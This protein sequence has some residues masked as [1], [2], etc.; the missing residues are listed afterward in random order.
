MS[1]SSSKLESLSVDELSA[2]YDR[3]GLEL[4]KKIEN[5]KRK[6]EQT[7]SNLRRGSVPDRTSMRSKGSSTNKRKKPRRQYPPVQPKYRN[8]IDRSQTWSGR[9][10]QP[11]WVAAQLKAGKKIDDFLIKGKQRRSANG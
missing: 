7:L 5:E 9:G 4:T 6:L 8:P 10:K 3:V 11:R 1:L 2:L